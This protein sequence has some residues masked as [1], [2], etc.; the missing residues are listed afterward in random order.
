MIL[1]RQSK[2][3]GQPASRRYYCAT[4]QYLRNLHQSTLTLVNLESG[5]MPEASNL[6]NC[7][8][9]WVRVCVICDSSCVNVWVCVHACICVCVYVCARACVGYAC[10]CVYARVY[11]YVSVC[12]SMY[13]RLYVH[14]SVCLYVCLCVCVFVCMVMVIGAWAL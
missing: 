1:R 5:L 9:V 11:A 12:V 10:V 13:I 3:C 7:W 8:G 2:L 6:R 14:V 4:L